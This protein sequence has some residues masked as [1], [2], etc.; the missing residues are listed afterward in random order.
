LIS[1]KQLLKKFFEAAAVD[2][3]QGF[4]VF[5]SAR[6]IKNKIYQKMQREKLY[7]LH[8]TICCL[9]LVI[10]LKNLTTF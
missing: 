2:N 6:L 7:N 1:L 8:E 9:L 3:R 10:I 4:S 5:A